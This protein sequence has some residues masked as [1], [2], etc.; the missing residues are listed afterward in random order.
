MSGTALW[1]TVEIPDIEDV[2][3]SYFEQDA[4]AVRQGP[5]GRADRQGVRQFA[6][7][8]QHGGLGI[9]RGS[10]TVHGD[11]YRSSDGVWAY[12]EAGLFLPPIINSQAALAAVDI[13]GHNAANIRVHQVSSTLGQSKRR[14]YFFVGKKMYR[15]VSDLDH[16]LEDTGLSMTDNVRFAFEGMLNDTRY[17]IVGFD[18]TTNDISVI[19]DPTLSPPVLSTAV[20]LSSGDWVD[21][22]A[23]LP[24]LGP[25]Y[26]VIHGKIGGITGWWYVETD[27]ALLTTL[28]PIV[29]TATRNLPNANNPSVTTVSQP[30]AFADQVPGPNNH[31]WDDIQ[32]IT[33]S[34]DTYATA[35]F[36]TGEVTDA[37][38]ALGFWQG[39]P[40]PEGTL[41]FGSQFLVEHHEDN[42]ADNVVINGTAGSGAYLVL[43]GTVTT[44]QRT[45]AGELTLADATATFGAVNDPWGGLTTAEVNSPRYGVGL[46]YT[47]LAGTS[48]QVL[49]D[50]VSNAITYKLPGVQAS[51]P[52]G[53]YVLGVDPLDLSTVYSVGPEFQ[54]E[55][56]SVEV[57]RILWRHD[58]VFDSIGNRPTVTLTKTPT[59]LR[60]VECGNFSAGG[61][62]VFGDTVE[63]GAKIGKLIASDK[64]IDLGFNSKDQGYTES[65]GV[66]N[67]WPSDRSVVF[68]AVLESGLVVQ[69]WLWDGNTGGCH[70]IGPRQPI[71]TPPIRYAEAALVGAELQRRYRFYPTMTNTSVSRQFQP[72]NV[73]ENPLSNNTTE[74]KANGTL[75]HVLPDLD[76][77]GPP[78][79]NK[80]VLTAWCLSREVSA[81]STIRLR[82]SIDGGL[83]FTTWTTFTAFGSKAV[84]SPPVAYRFLMLEIALAHTADSANTPNGLPLLIEFSSSWR[85]LRQW[86]VTF[87]GNGERLWSLYKAGPDEL[88]NA[89]ATL[90]NTLG[91]QT[92]RH[93]GLSYKTEA[94][95]FEA[96]YQIP[97]Q[98]G[99]N[100]TAR[101]DP[102]RHMGQITIREVAQ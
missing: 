59:G 10:E 7:T 68:D 44:H 57:P 74:I 2:A 37:L 23:F 99:A 15:T 33:A 52:L 53:G 39:S 76:I 75:A 18:G 13:S 4:Q 34:D 43:D 28:M 95:S 92:F 19:A 61:L 30:A 63:G 84:L 56:G 55:T 77:G 26:V 32:N 70:P 5:G 16:S 89:I 49:V 50:Y 54:D 102:R 82:Y 66:V 17:I 29:L 40:F 79:K 36:L 81:S 65:W 45:V 12:Q 11:R 98:V 96:N 47:D 31:E 69:T 62:V 100:P 73:F 9:L 6:I 41:F 22:G 83:N 38:L 21:G 14:E 78:E 24:H 25:G 51:M 8:T 27:E 35:G 80:A 85:M 46:V 101:N 71:T 58:L 88:V 42:L 1:G 3:L 60:H 93:G 20:A 94:A 90:Q 86:L 67:C 48:P 64:I 91:V 87:N 97:P 72:R